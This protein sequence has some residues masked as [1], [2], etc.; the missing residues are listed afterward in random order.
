MTQTIATLRPTETISFDQG[1]LAAFC[2][3][4]GYEAESAI[5]RHLSEIETL[6]DLLCVQADHPAGLARTCHDLSAAAGR[7]G[8]AS[9][10]DGAE[11]VLDC[12]ARD[13]RTALAACTAR[14]IRQCGPMQ[15]GGWVMAPTPDTVA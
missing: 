6:I 4:E 10:R 8:M 14:L 5:T 7:I 13:D 2:S 15:T 3:A 9:I 12:L 11:A 1:T